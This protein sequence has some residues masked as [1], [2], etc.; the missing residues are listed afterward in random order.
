MKLVL[1]LCVFLLA[2]PSGLRGHCH[3]CQGCCSSPE[4]VKC[5]CDENCEIYRN[6]CGENS[7]TDTSYSP[8]SAHSSSLLNVTIDCISPYTNSAINTS[9]EGY[10]MITSCPS[11]WVGPVS[12]NITTQCNTSGTASPPVTDLKTGHVYRNEYCALCNRVTEMAAWSPQLDCTSLIHKLISSDVTNAT[13]MIVNECNVTSFLPPHREKKTDS[14]KLCVPYQEK[15][16]T[17]EELEHENANVKMADYLILLEQC[18]SGPVNP[19]QGMN[20]KEVYKNRACAQCNAEVNVKCAPPPNI[21]SENSTNISSTPFRKAIIESLES[22]ESFEFVLI[23]KC[24][25]GSNEKIT[26][27][28]S[29][30]MGEIPVGLTCQPT[31]CPEGFRSNHR[32]CAFADYLAVLLSSTSTDCLNR[33]AIIS[34]ETYTDLGNST[35]VLNQNGYLLEVLDYNQM[36]H[37]IV[38]QDNV[39][40]EMAVL[41]CNTALTSLDE[42]KYTDYMNDTILVGSKLISVQFHDLNSRPLICPDLLKPSPAPLPGIQLITFVGCT[43]SVFGVAAV[44]TTYA[45]FSDLHTF[46]GLVLLNVCITVLFTSGLGI[47]RALIIQYYPLSSVCSLLAV[48]IH[49][50]YLAQFS[51][52]SIFSFEILK[53]FYQ[54]TNNEEISKQKKCKLLI[55]YL[56]I[57]WVLPLLINSVSATLHYTTSSMLYGVKGQKEIAEC[58]INHYQSFIIAFLL[59]LVLSLVCNITFMGMT[60]LLL[61]TVEENQSEVDKSNI[62][63]R[64]RM[65]LAIFAITA[66]TWAFGFFAILEK[67]EWMWYIFVILNSTQGFRISLAF[68]FTKKVYNLYANLIRRT[69][70]INLINSSKIRK[71]NSFL[72]TRQEEP[73]KLEMV[74]VP[75]MTDTEKDQ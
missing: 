44:I 64:I 71:I 48:F 63:I 75:L 57:G 21:P 62:A 55:V 68:I 59:P 40:I 8:E 17:H 70:K 58:W 24:S 39:S 45:V 34:N 6:C 36:G 51:W 35:V 49:Y 15:C 25:V 14:P 69:L 2:L 12:L 38:C 29:C 74:L 41:N 65:W 26:F 56:F 73:M 13:E 52:M 37:P 47:S 28:I 66:L 33:I 72:Q 61:C 5:Q 19:V 53:G 46:P 30:P 54:T 50:F 10:Y 22:E 18:S 67:V 3:H 27:K 42:S 16:M 31:L 60:A 23:L 7:L 32:R 20:T 1:S 9:K 11:S 4:N 43:L